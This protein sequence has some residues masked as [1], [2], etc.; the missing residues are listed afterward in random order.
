MRAAISGI[1]R[2]PSSYVADATFKLDGD[3]TDGVWSNRHE[4]LLG[5]DKIDTGYRVVVSP[6]QIPG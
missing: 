3:L 1:A 2:P 5:R 6:G 4:D